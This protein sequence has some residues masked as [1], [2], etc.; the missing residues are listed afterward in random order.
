MKKLYKKYISNNV[1]L[2]EFDKILNDYISHHNRKFYFYFVKLA[3][4]IKFNTNFIPRID[5]NYCFNND[6]GNLKVYLVHCIDYLKLRGYIFQEK[7]EL[8]ID[9]LN[10]RFNTTY[11][12]YIN[13]SMDMCERK[14]NMVIARNPQLI[15]SL[16]RNKSH[17]L[18]RK[19]SHIPYKN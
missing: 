19:N 12:H 11:E 6:I 14:I 10:D 8:V 18:I 17:P 13:R 9:T 3:F 16:H 1:N 2:V 7:N 15:N 4:E 5:T